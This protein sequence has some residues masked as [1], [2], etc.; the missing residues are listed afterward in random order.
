MEG[1]VLSFLKAEWAHW[2]SSFHKCIALNIG[3][4]GKKEVFLKALF[5]YDPVYFTVYKDLPRLSSQKFL[6]RLS[7]SKYDMIITT[8][9][10]S[11]QPGDKYN[12]NPTANKRVYSTFDFYKSPE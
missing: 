5:K 2:A 7:Q 6:R 12:L 9:I 4:L 1:S 8:F 11:S 10:F 3:V